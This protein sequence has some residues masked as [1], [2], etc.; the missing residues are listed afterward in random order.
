MIRQLKID[1]TTDLFPSK[2]EDIS[3]RDKNNNTTTVQ[4]A[5]RALET[6]GNQNL[7]NVTIYVIGDSTAADHHMYSKA[8]IYRVLARRMNCSI[9]NYHNYAVAGAYIRSN[10]QTNYNKIGSDAT[11]IFIQGGYNDVNRNEGET[12]YMAIGNISEILQLSDNDSRLTQTVLGNYYKYIKLILDSK[13]GKIF[14]IAP[15]KT[16]LSGTKGE[17]Y[18][19]FRAGVE[20]IVNHLAVGVNYNRIFYIDGYVVGWPDFVNDTNW[21]WARDNSQK[22]HPTTDGAIYIANNIY[23]WIYSTDRSVFNDLREIIISPTTLTM[24][25]TVNTSVEATF[26]VKALRSGN[27]SLSMGTAGNN[28]FTINP[29]KITAKN[30]DI[31]ETTVTVTYNPQEAES[32]TQYKVIIKNNGLDSSIT[33]NASAN[34]QSE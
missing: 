20:A 17:R 11:H 16:S 18:A 28:R 27:L 33:I 5:L 3:Y 1:E 6:G 14:C 15:F 22:V 30:N 34:A 26:T 25:T 32:T 24:S 23:N 12:G 31:P 2:A 7:S 19:T 4:A 8:S 13:P 10:L 29:N 9:N 21:D